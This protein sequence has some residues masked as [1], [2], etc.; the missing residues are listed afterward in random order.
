MD[1]SDNPFDPGWDQ[2]FIANK[3]V[4]G[5]GITAID[6]NAFEDHHGE[7]QTTSVVFKEPCKVQSIG[8][9]AFRGTDLTSIEIPDS[10]TEIGYNAFDTTPLETITIGKNVKDIG[11]DVFNMCTSLRSI[12]VDEDN[13]YYKSVDGILYNKKMTQ[14]ICYPPQKSG[15]SFTVPNSVRVIRANAFS[16]C[17]NLSSI[18]IPDSVTTIGRCAFMSCNSLVTMSIPEGVTQVDDHVFEYCTSLV[19]VKLP[20][21]TARIGTQTFNRCDNLSKIIFTGSEDR[22]NKIDISILNE[23]LKYCNYEFNADYDR[24]GYNAPKEYSGT[25]YF[26]SGKGSA[27]Y[28]Y[29]DS[30][31]AAS[32]YKYNHNLAR[33]SI[34][35]ALSAFSEKGTYTQGANT[36]RFLSELEF[37]EVDENNFY[38]EEAQAESIA[39][40]I[41]NKQVTYADGDYTLVAVAVRGGNYN[42]EWGGNFH[43]SNGRDADVHIGFYNASSQVL[44]FLETYLR[45]NNISGKVKIWMTSYSRG[46]AAVNLAAARLN[47]EPEWWIPDGVEFSPDN[48][49]AYCFETP[50]GVV[51]PDN[52]SGLYNNIFCIINANDVVPMVAMKKWG[53]TR[54]GVTKVLP[55]T[56]T[57][58]KKAYNAMEEVVA[59]QFETYYGSEY[60]INNFEHA[61]SR[62]K[63]L[64]QSLYLEGLINKAATA[65]GNTHNYN[66]SLQSTAISI[67]SDL[68]GKGLL[69]ELINSFKG[70]DPVSIISIL[71][72]NLDELDIKVTPYTMKTIKDIIVA[73]GAS[74]ITTLVN[75]FEP[76]A[77]GHEPTLC[78]AW[79]D[80]IEAEH[81]KAMKQ[82]IAKIKCPV[83]VNVYDENNT[84]VASIINDEVI[85]YE[86]NL[87]IA[88][89]DENGQKIL[90]MPRDENYRIEIIA[91]DDGNVTYSVQEDDYE[92][93][94]TR[95]TNYYDIPIT[96]TDTLSAQVP[97]ITEDTPTDYTLSRND[98]V[99]EGE[100]IEEAQQYQVN[101]YGEGNG[102]AAGG[103]YYYKGEYAKFSA[104]P[105]EYEEFLGWY[106]DGELVSTEP[107][108]SMRIEDSMDLTAQ[109]TENTC[110][111]T[112]YDQEE[113]IDVFR[114]KKNTPTALSKAYLKDGHFFMGLYSDWDMTEIL[115]NEVTLD[116]DTTIYAKFIP[117]ELSGKNYC[118]YN[119]T[120]QD[121]IFK[122][123]LYLNDSVESQEGVLIIAFYDDNGHL[124]DLK[125]QGITAAAGE[126]EINVPVENEDYLNYKIMVWKDAKN[127]EPILEEL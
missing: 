1:T 61:S 9:Y 25:V 26:K 100:V 22:W 76:I 107:E 75:N 81:F 124:T 33:A 20:A 123:T 11:E 12:K 15:T 31:F 52:A 113:I 118:I 36:T 89:V 46:S 8:D 88:D 39:V 13:K 27:A 99:F 102:T 67:G 120:H 2:D 114:V 64:P 121:S 41:G 40:A 6:N 122:G 106:K 95:L 16:N 62:K 98:T 86:D 58:S 109:F 111:V 21:T 47:E 32:A 10:V 101:V 97:V 38:S 92:A 127:M 54:Y 42:S 74:D 3:I 66:N 14:L 94:T 60:I 104:T 68:M 48:F 24:D 28:T 80:T 117:C 73:I 77:Q 126:N 34:R 115:A 63:N 125:L 53:F 30:Y 96:R 103:G 108:L 59:R 105:D 43:V 5:T 35:L 44:D 72:R 82:R 91:T 87:I 23:K 56:L 37:D 49:Y 7:H 85:D 50:A 69:G 119:I 71:A 51:N 57:H 19:T 110:E 4:I 29:S 90:Y 45:T 112:V 65:V 70:E 18:P 17:K 79:L 93:G 78:M 55:S 116:S 83:D 84:L